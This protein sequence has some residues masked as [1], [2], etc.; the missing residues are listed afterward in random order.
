MV[1]I[2]GQTFRAW[3][4]NEQGPLVR[5]SFY[6]PAP[7]LPRDELARRIQNQNRLPGVV[8]ICT[9]QQK[10]TT[11]WRGT[12]RMGF[13]CRGLVSK[14]TAEEIKKAG[15]ILDCRLT[16]YKVSF[17]VEKPKEV[18][19]A[20][21]G[22]SKPEYKAKRITTRYQPGVVPD[23]EKEFWSYTKGERQRVRRLM[24][25]RGLRPFP[26]NP[27]KDVTPGNA[28][29]RTKNRVKGSKRARD[30]NSKHDGGSGSWAD[31]RER[32]DCPRTHTRMLQGDPT[33]YDPESPKWKAD[34]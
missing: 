4:R 16:S 12:K 9:M 30:T 22:T 5:F 31:D 19:L 11:D 14:D 26:R 10:D 27:P 24:E 32:V 33:P 28:N 20:D 1:T 21:V 15:N 3:R 8:K 29:P 7:T 25:V 34:P 23:T 18:A 2:K 6:A 13:Y 17:E